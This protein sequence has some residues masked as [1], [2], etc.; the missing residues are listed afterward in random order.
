[1]LYLITTTGKT[2]SGKTTFWKKLWEKLENSCIINNDTMTD[3]LREAYPKLYQNDFNSN[4][5]ISQWYSLK[6]A[7]ITALFE[8][9]TQRGLNII[10]TNCLRT[11]ALRMKLKQYTEKKK[12]KFILIYF[13]F[14]DTV[15]QQRILETDRWNEDRQ[16][17]QERFF[18]V[19][20]RQN[21]N[22][23]TANKEEA[24][25]FFEITKEE[26]CREIEE[27]ILRIIAER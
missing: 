11:K 2:H 7:I 3:F 8:S 21:K 20:E 22:Y 13:N 9:A 15:L 26:D 27:Q 1:M 19:L 17:H 14:P 5:T 24:D 16:L 10:A 12:M 25:F 4:G 6:H 23:E 18:R